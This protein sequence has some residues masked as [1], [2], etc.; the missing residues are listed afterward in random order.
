LATVLIYTKGFNLM[1]GKPGCG[2][3]LVALD[4]AGHLAADLA[5]GSVVYIAA[6]GREGLY[7]RWQAWQQ[8]NNTI[9]ENVFVM[10]QPLS[11]FDQEQI[12]RFIDHCKQLS[13][14]F[15]IVDTLARS[16]VGENE[17]DTTAMGL[18]VAAVDQLRNELDC[19]VLFIHHTN[20]IGGMRGSTVLDGALDSVLKIEALDER[21]IGVFNSLEKGGKNKDREEAQPIYLNKLPVEVLVSGVVENAV[22]VELS[23]RVIQTPTS[24]TL[25]AKQR[26]ILEMLDTFTDGL[27]AKSIRDATGIAQSTLYDQLGKLTQAEYIQQDKERYLLTRAGRE[28]CH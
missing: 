22:V 27:T 11:M 14:R 23:E 21:Q 2:K 19:G 28:A 18:F 5:D 15:V 9:L 7:T 3:S 25:S 17:N 1:Y 8:H 13:V 24:D 12:A 4:F 20:K 10:L 16:M 26:Q 6:E